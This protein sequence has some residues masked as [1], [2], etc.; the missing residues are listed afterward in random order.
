MGEKR[1]L[2]VSDWHDEPRPLPITRAPVARQLRIPARLIG[3][4]GTVLLHGLV[5]QTVLLG[6]ST[7]QVLTPTT[8]GLASTANAAGAESEMTL[9]VVQP[10]KPTTK[11]SVFEEFVSRGSLLK[12]MPIALIS[13]DVT[14][15]APSLKKE[16]LTDN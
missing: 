8:Q 3:I 12:D 9:V 11:D 13:R 4:V 10:V 14:T 15:A 2:E 7:T 1:P 5:V 16:R 6:T